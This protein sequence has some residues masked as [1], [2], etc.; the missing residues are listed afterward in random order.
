MQFA[1]DS[2]TKQI[3]NYFITRGIQ[4][5]RICENRF[6]EWVVS[7]ILK[8]R[9]TMFV[10]NLN[11]VFREHLLKMFEEAFKAH[12]WT[13][14]QLLDILHAKLSFYVKKRVW[15]FYPI[16]IQLPISLSHDKT[17]NYTYKLDFKIMYVFPF[18]LLKIFNKLFSTFISWKE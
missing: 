17:H 3:S 5:Y 14:S 10:V 6:T 16:F 15:I 9:W 4:R 12:F 1:T 8:K 11:I 13:L 2:Q 18:S 7:G